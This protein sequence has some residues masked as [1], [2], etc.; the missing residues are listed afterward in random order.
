MT[1]WGDAIKAANE[2]LKLYH[3]IEKSVKDL[4]TN[5]QLTRTDVSSLR[6]EIMGLSGRV[7]MLEEGRKTIAAEVNAAMASGL[8]EIKIA[9]AE[10]I[11]QLKVDY[12]NELSKLFQRNLEFQRDL[13]RR[14]EADHRATQDRP[15][16]PNPKD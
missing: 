4:E 11:A 16:L 12:A 8:A 3:T 14:H 9:K 2:A 7:S 1:V 10:T 5:F 6:L 13:D 15:S